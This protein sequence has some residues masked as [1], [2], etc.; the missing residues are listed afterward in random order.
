MIVQSVT[1]DTCSL[2]TVVWPET[3]Q[4]QNGLTN[5][6]KIQAAIKSGRIQGFFCESLITLEG[7]Q[8]RNRP[9]V[10]GSTR[11]ETRFS[12]PDDQTININIAVKQ[13]RNPLPEKFNARIRA[14]QALGMRALRGPARIGWVTV[15]DKDGTLFKP[16]DSVS[17]LTQR[18]DKVHELATAI[19]TRGVGQAV[20][21]RLG[22]DLLARAGIP[23]PT[24][25]PQGLQHAQGNRERDEISSAIAEWADGDSVAAHY[26]YGIDLLCTEDR[27]KGASAASVLDENNRIWLQSEYGIRFVSL[28]ELA[29]KLT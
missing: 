2:D 14:A 19:A 16:Y 17:E 10:L 28:A 29:D 25:W 5:G 20:A 15:E 7:V 23:Q 18:L 1:F 27:G 3:S 6:R 24:L 11:L 22:L 4:H 9:E 8:R 12:S 13:D 26:G 21:V